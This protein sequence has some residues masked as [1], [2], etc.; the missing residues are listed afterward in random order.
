MKAV[1]RAMAGYTSLICAAGEEK[2]KDCAEMRSKVSSAPVHLM[3]QADVVAVS[4]M[5]QVAV[6]EMGQVAVS[7]I[8]TPLPEREFRFAAVDVSER[9]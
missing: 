4:E 2:K 1:A 7:H 6:A 3:G 8:S 9:G 5:G